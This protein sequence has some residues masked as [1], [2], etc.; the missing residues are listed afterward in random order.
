MSSLLINQAIARSYRMGQVRDVL[1]YRLLTE[2]SI[3]SSLM[4]LLNHKQILFDAYAKE[5]YLADNSLEA[6][7][8]SEKE[9][10]NSIL[11]K[12]KEKLN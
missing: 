7:D 6:K 11:K 9:I 4:E 12:E 8:L 2:N 5:S 1:V 3:D 10:I